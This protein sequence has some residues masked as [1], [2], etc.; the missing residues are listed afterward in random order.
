[1]CRI[2][3]ASNKGKW[4][5]ATMLVLVLVALCVSSAPAFAQMKWGVVSSQGAWVIPVKY[6]N[7]KY[8]GGEI[9]S[10]TNFDHGGLYP[11]GKAF[12]LDGRGNP[13]PVKLPPECVLNGPMVTSVE[14]ATRKDDIFLVIIRGG[15]R[16]ICDITGKVIVPPV[17]AEVVSYNDGYFIARS[18]NE[19]STQFIDRQ[20]VQTGT[21]S[22]KDFNFSFNAFH[23][24]FI[25]GESTKREVLGPG[26]V[27][28]NFKYFRPDGTILN[29]PELC[30]GTDFVDGYASVGVAKSDGSLDYAARLSSSGKLVDFGKKLKILSS[31]SSGQ[32][33]AGDTAPDPI[34][35]SR[36]GVIDENGNFIIPPKYREILRNRNDSYI[37]RGEHG[38]V[39]LDRSG[40]VICRWQDGIEVQP[41]Q[42]K[43]HRFVVRNRESVSAN[44]EDKLSL[45]DESGK[46]LSMSQLPLNQTFV[47]GEKVG[48]KSV[49]GLWRNNRWITELA[50]RNFFELPNNCWIALSEPVKFDANDW[51]LNVDRREQFRLLLQERNLIGM[52]RS[53]LI[54]LLGEG[55]QPRKDRLYYDLAGPVMCGN[56][57]YG[58]I[59]EFQSNSVKRWSI[60][61]PLPFGGSDE[62]SDWFT[63]DVCFPDARYLF[64]K[65]EA[66]PKQ[67]VK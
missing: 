4:T 38:D 11:I 12:L 14:P 31:F 16:G 67:N 57:S 15:E 53:N 23:D 42:T 17:Y 27:K 8:L 41:S 34:K 65:S 63:T 29:S 64:K 52:P 37:A 10:A 66:K 25:L 20:G 3:R 39:L 59:F 60:S 1:M 33:I 24:G 54:G 22:A 51:Q 49:C 21:V 5:L 13:F 30:F 18:A 40:R 26:I 46:I 35:N 55:Q 19:N 6:Q 7:I 9:Y 61:S 45:S 48:E 44:V 43:I 50:F 62:K 56:A 28:S 47:I 2:V 58:V 36:M 32:A